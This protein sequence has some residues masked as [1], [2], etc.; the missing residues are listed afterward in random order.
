MI[1]PRAEA[2]SRATRYAL[3]LVEWLEPRPGESLIDV[4]CGDGTV[5]VLLVR[6][7]APDGRVLA[8]DPE[9][10]VVDRL[11][12]R[13]L[14]LGLAPA[15]EVVQGTAGELAGAV[16]GW[17]PAGGCGGVFSS[18]ALH[19]VADLEALGAALGQMRRVLAPHG[20]LAVQL[21]GAGNAAR[22]LEAADAVAR[23]QRLPSAEAGHG[24][25]LPGLAELG[26]LAAEA[27]LQ[28]VVVERRTEPLGVDPAATRR[29][30]VSLARRH[31]AG[32]PPAAA[33]AYLDEVVEV[34]CP[35]GQ[36]AEE[37]LVRLLCR[38]R[39]PA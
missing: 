8:V 1:A 28:D 20:R 29:L 26:A 27:G 36:P 15:L 11:R 23:R 5:S 35:G 4:G 18:G 30:A 21:G 24:W 31:L 9:P 13:A 33:A 17:L 37:R 3:E 19:F 16:R 39:R 12:E 22:L 10:A 25:T 6:R 7:T 38:A 34:V 14:L 32:L 2:P